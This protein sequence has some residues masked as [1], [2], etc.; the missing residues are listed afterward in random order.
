MSIFHLKFKLVRNFTTFHADQESSDYKTLAH[1]IKG[2]FEAV[3]EE[4]ETERDTNGTIYIHV[5][6][7]L[8]DD[9]VLVD[10]RAYIAN[11]S[12]TTQEEMDLLWSGLFSVATS[13]DGYFDP[14]ILLVLST[15]LCPNTSWSSPYGI[16]QFSSGDL[17]SWSE[18][19][20]DCPWFTVNDG[21]PIAR[22]VC[23]GDY[24]SPCAWV[25]SDNCGGN[26]TADQLLI[27][28][29]E[30]LMSAD[31]QDVLSFLT[32]ISQDKNINYA[33]VSAAFDIIHQTVS[34]S[35]PTQENVASVVDILSILATLDKGLIMEAEMMDGAVSR[36]T[37]ALEEILLASKVPSNQAFQHV[38]SNLVVQAYTPLAEKGH[39]HQE[40]H[41]PGLK[42]SVFL[43]HL[44]N[45]ATYAELSFNFR[46]G[47]ETIQKF[48]PDVARAVVDEYAAECFLGQIRQEPDTVRLLIEAAV[49]LH[50]LIR[51]QYQAWDVRML[52]Q[53]DAQHNLIPR[54]WRTAAI[55]VRKS[56]N[57]ALLL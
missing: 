14:S 40:G 7:L 47:K 57:A 16:V 42:L 55:T 5:N 32:V 9:G 31:V 56:C 34:I 25:P 1:D 30:N 26:K 49:M 27:Y 6:Q 41:S 39:P 13:S 51:N 22:A 15:V 2:K 53:E 46:M 36:A 38:A 35:Q 45:G 8:P 37:V 3:F 10:M 48:V 54:A 23:S 24:I 33:G 28:L 52:D 12:M 50:N 44:A 29:Q 4:L 43:R 11:S 19:S 20:G 21:E 17:H 18:S